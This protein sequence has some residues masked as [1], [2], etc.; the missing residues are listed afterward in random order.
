MT[1]HDPDRV[2][3][4][5]V[6][7][8]RKACPR[9]RPEGSCSNKNIERDDDSKKS[10]HAL[11]DIAAALPNVRFTPESGHRR[12]S[13]AFPLSAKSRHDGFGT[14]LAAQ[15][16]LPKEAWNEIIGEQ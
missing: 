6:A 11:A 10:H 5:C 7:V 4:K 8:F 3:A 15:E 2:S 13:W 16:R 12:A 14:V 1:E 9:A